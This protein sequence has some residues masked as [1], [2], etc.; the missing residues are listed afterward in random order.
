M[1]IFCCVHKEFSK[2]EQYQTQ[3]LKIGTISSY[4]IFSSIFDVRR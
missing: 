1:A 2:N 3:S 4:E